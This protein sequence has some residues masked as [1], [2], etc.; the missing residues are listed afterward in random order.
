MPKLKAFIAAHKTI[1][2]ILAAG[3]LMLGYWAFKTYSAGSIETRYV[4]ASVQKGTIITSISG[5]GQVSAFSQ[6]D[7]KSKASGDITY[8]AVKNAQKV[9]AGA[10]LAQLD[11]RDAQK[12]VRDA[13]VNLDNAK[14]SLAKLKKPADDYSILQ[15]QNAVQNSKNTLEKLKFSQPVDYQKA[16][17]AEQKAQDTLAKVYDDSLTT[18]SDTF[19]DLPTVMSGLYDVI[20]G[21]AIGASEAI[22]GRE[23][24]NGN[25]LL[26]TIS[27]TDDQDALKKLLLKTQQDYQTA[28]TK[29]DTNFSHYKDSSRYAEKS[30]TVALV[31]ET[32]ETTKSIAQAAKSENDLL[33]AWTD[34]RTKHL[35]TIFAK[36]TSYKTNLS[37]YISEVNIHLSNLLTIQRTLL[38]DEQALTNAQ[39][40]LKT[41]DQNNPLDMA[42][43]QASVKEKEESLKKLKAGADILDI[44]SQE[45]TVQQRENTFA[46]AKEKLVDYSIRA[47]FDGVIAKLDVKNWDSVSSS[48]VIATLV[49]TQ[50]VADISLNE[51]DVAK[52]KLREKATLTFDAIDGLSISGKVAEIDTVGTVNQGVVTYN[53]KISFDT[54][55]DRVKPGMSVSAAIITNVKQ[56]VL[57]V[58]NAAV[59]SLNEAQYVEMFDAPM[60]QDQGAQG[61]ISA[62]APRRQ[63]VETGLSNDTSTE[64]ISGLKEGDQI[65]TRTISGVTTAK[66][67]TAAPSIFG[68]GGGFGGALRGG[69][70]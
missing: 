23:Q 11:D 7:V 33:S 20:Y 21:N 8:V 60:P 63:P 24:S 40:S 58:A 57:V 59:K 22:I 65:V 30:A 62:V 53:V 51:V 28:R 49:T 32:L 2:A 36:V 15:A 18:V 6:V 26:N 66:T 39:N 37:T 5:S 16:K 31:A 38:D 44:K 56:D 55:D 13:R 43:A 34:Y 17:D 46:D 68:G 45:L 10:V 50:R 12:A 48:T 14:L 29:Y 54:Q 4:L 42:A 41:M 25:A 52:I 47:P 3:A 1:S 69:G 61:I 67:A 19:L 27:N 35:Q 70:R 64:I 9:K